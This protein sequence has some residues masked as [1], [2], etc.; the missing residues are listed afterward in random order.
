MKPHHVPRSGLTLTYDLN[1]TILVPSSGH[2][3][4]RPRLKYLRIISK[5]FTLIALFP[6]WVPA[7]RLH[8]HL[9]YNQVLTYPLKSTIFEAHI[10]GPK[11]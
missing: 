9:Y 7:N 4:L 5:L 1:P 3:H 2:L 10:L 6:T 11:T 8:L